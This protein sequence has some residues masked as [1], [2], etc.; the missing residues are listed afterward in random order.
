M[1]V[2]R[3][4]T[5][6]RGTASRTGALADLVEEQWRI[7]SGDPRVVRRHLG[8]DPL[9]ATAWRD[10]VG[11]HWTPAE[12]QTS[13]QKEA[14]ALAATLVDE[15]VAADALIIAAPLYNFG[16]S[17]H[18]KTWVD[19]ITTDSRMGKGHEPVLAG[20]PAVLLTA[21]G[22][23]YGPGTP[24][25]GWDHATGWMRQV[26]GE[27]WGLDLTVIEQELVFVGIDPALDRFKEAADRVRIDAEEQART[28]GRSLAALKVAA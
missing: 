12:Q 9:P 10:A 3:L 16:V 17:Q 1:S 15:L 26:F 20:K 13:E 24:R 21:R 8:A 4:D 19:V 11:A 5:S 27:V 23:S 6:I 18:L 22:G 2:F 14:A 25:E 7:E 28:A